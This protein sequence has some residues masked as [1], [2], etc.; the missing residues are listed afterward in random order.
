MTSILTNNGAI[1]ALQTL[2]MTNKYLAKTQNEISTGKK[3]NTAADGSAVWS[4]AKTMESDRDMFKVIGDGLNVATEVV[5]TA[6]ANAKEIVDDLDKIKQRLGASFNPDQ[7]AKTNWNEI[8]EL[9]DGIKGKINNAQISGVNLLKKD[10]IG[11]GK[12]T[13][14]VLASLDRSY[15]KVTTEQTVINVE[16][17]DLSEKVLKL[18][19][20]WKAIETSDAARALISGEVPNVPKYVKADFDKEVAV[21]NHADTTDETKA[22]IEAKYTIG[23]VKG[24]DIL[25]KT[26]TDADGF[27]AEYTSDKTG[28][29]SGAPVDFDTY[30]SEQAIYATAT[31]TAERKAELEAKYTVGDVKGA[32]V[33]GT[34]IEKRADY[35]AEYA[36]DALISKSIESLHAVAKEAVAYLG[37]KQA[38]IQSQT[39]SVGRLADSL[40]T[41]I[42]AM[43]DA[44]L[45]EA[46][47]RLQALQTQ[48]QLGI[49]ALSIANQAP[50]SVLSLFR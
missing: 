17:A 19:E 31:T 35:E 33:L 24:K 48:Q 14:T 34:K 9:V 40:T 11:A 41:A 44:D 29:A 27:K 1:I 26:F 42:G 10:G 8:K 2:K 13:Y 25:G 21:Y 5:S 50:Q 36:G 15:G 45:E 37:A 7:D 32:D 49:Q 28:I 4:V 30:A 22:A 43:V 6:R 47:A 18:L 12:N 39:E 20:S 23:N 16:S 3:I 46:S 38:R